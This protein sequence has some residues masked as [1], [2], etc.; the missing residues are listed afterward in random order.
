M[1]GN[2]KFDQQLPDELGDPGY[3]NYFGKEKLI[4]LAAST[5]SGE[6]ALI[7]ETFT[8]LKKE[9]ENLK[10]VLVPR[11]AERAAEVE[12]VVETFRLS[13]CRRTAG[14]PANEVD[15]LIAD[16]TGEMLKLMSGADVVIMGKSL[17][18]HDEGHN[19][20]EPALLHKP[21]VTGSVLRNFRVLLKLL[22]DGRGVVTVAEDK[23]LSGALA[24]LFRSPELRK[25]YGERGFELVSA[26]R[27]ATARSV[28]ELE[29]LIKVKD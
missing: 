11:H 3:E 20:I 9:F 5:H 28:A 15:V 6:E 10:L 17:A 2:L 8:E 7:T 21:V 4:L 22:V 1:T 12:S 25:N 16:T 26:N 13:Q 23:E 19:L 27:G 24:E 14:I 29:K 18:G